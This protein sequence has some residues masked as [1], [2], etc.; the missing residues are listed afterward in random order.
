MLLAGNFG[1]SPS[2][3]QT[4]FALWAIFAAPLFMS[5]DLRE[6]PAETKAMLQNREVIAVNQ[7]GC[8]GSGMRKSLESLVCAAWGCLRFNS[9][10]TAPLY[11][12]RSIFCMP[13]G[14]E[15]QTAEVPREVQ[16]VAQHTLQGALRLR[17]IAGRQCAIWNIV[18][19][20]APAQDRTVGKVT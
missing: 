5:N 18:L 4:Q 13:I 9:S 17:Q 16:P 12:R 10:F 7:D 11:S 14:S 2:E 15:G 8:C 20:W 1:L 19:L 6:I 3:E